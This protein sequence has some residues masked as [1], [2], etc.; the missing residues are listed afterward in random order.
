MIVLTDRH[1]AE[2]PGG[3]LE[4]VVAAALDAGAGAVVLREK[5]LPAGRRHRLAEG[6]RS[7]TAVRRAELW[8]AGDVALAAAIGADGVHLAADQPCPAPTPGLRVGRSCH[9]L[10]ELTGARDE[11]VDRVTYSPVY[12][13][14][15]KPGYGPALGPEGLATGCKAVAGL[16]VIALGGVEPGNAGACLSAGAAGVALMGAVMRADDP[17]AVVRSVIDELRRAHA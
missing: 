5:D 15:S 11:G 9:T 16:P 6:L 3:G 10:A 12:V 1:A 17:A 13:S 7:A 2:G 8:V 14:A 4:A